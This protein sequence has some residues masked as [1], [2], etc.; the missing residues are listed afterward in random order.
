MAAL[1]YHPDSLTLDPLQGVRR[2]TDTIPMHSLQLQGKDK[3]N[4][5]N[6]N[7]YRT[8]IFK[9]SIWSFQESADLDI[10]HFNGVRK[11]DNT[12]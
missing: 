7:N 9:K 1:V 3:G 8:T 10:A 2:I 4:F 6:K 12:F 11:K 5:I